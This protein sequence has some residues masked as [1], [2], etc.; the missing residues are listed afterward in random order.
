MPDIHYVP[1]S[2]LTGEETLLGTP[3]DPSGMV[4][5]VV[6]ADGD[7]A[8]DEAAEYAALIALSR[9]FIVDVL[10]QDGVE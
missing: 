1:V 9:V 3:P 5:V 2:S 8:P 6:P 4:A 7:R 10:P